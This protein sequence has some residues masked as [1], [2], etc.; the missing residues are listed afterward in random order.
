ML[1]CVEHSVEVTA[2]TLYEAV[3]Q[4]WRVFGESEWRI[5]GLQETLTVAQ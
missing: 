5:D 3:A 2:Q 4:G 1:Q